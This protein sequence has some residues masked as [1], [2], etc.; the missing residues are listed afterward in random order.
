M[1]R[2]LLCEG[3]TDAILLSYYLCKVCGWSYTKKP[4]KGYNFKG[5]EYNWYKL[6]DSE[7]YLLICDVGGVNNFKLFFNNNIAPSLR[8]S[9]SFEKVSFIVDKDERKIEDIINEFKNITTLIT[10]LD[11]NNWITNFYISDYGEEH[12]IK[13]FILVVPSEKEGA[14]ETIL[15]DSLSEHSSSDKLIVNKSCEFIDTIAPSAENYIRK[16]RLQLKAKLG[17]TFAIM[18]PQKVF[19]FI[20]E[21][22]KTVEWEKS[23]SLSELF[24]ELSK[25]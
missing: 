1:N 13:A 25:I 8:V 19:S 21:Q 4:P 7:E 24:S 20:D 17:V 16:K 6:K 12:S 14:L 2:L 23:S 5:K 3:Q 22:I 11:N 10:D 9:A 15:L 18:S